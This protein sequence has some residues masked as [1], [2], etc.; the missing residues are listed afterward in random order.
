MKKVLGRFEEYI[1]IPMLAFSAIL[2]F[3]QV[4]MRYVFSNSLSW[5]EELARFLYIWEVWLGIAYCTKMQTHLRITLI[6]SFTSKKIEQ[7]IRLFINVIWFGFGL[8]LVYVGAATMLQIRDFG[9]VSSALRL[10]MWIVYLAIPVGA[11]L[12]DIHLIEHS[13]TLVKELVKGGA[14][15]E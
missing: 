6:F 13:I 12:M 15:N 3:V 4:I 11:F 5:S 8:F 9:Q 10:P 2:L 14:D 1:L 7:I